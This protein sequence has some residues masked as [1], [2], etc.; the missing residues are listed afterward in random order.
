MRRSLGGRYANVT[1]TLALMVALGGTS[2]AAI[3]LPANS[4]GSAQIK[5]KAVGSSDLASGAVTSAKV[6]DGS[7]LGTDFKAGELPRGRTGATGPAGA[8]G[9]TGP[10]GAPGAPGSAGVTGP[11][12]PSDGYSATTQSSVTFTGA[13]QTLQ[14]L[15]LPAGKF[16]LNAV[17]AADNNSALQ[18][19]VSCSLLSGATVLASS[20]VNLAPDPGIDRANISLAGALAQ[21]APGSVTLRCTADTAVGNFPASA[22]TAIRVE[23]LNGG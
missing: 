8:T 7:L 19:S 14:T 18:H 2:Y 11:R 12:G 21:G 10:V 13:E 9:A 6:K 4:V 1:S 5:A 16:V 15:A 3:K 22:L 20:Q 17:A 23:T